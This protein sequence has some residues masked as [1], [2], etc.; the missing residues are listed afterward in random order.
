[1]KKCYYIYK[2]TNLLNGKSYIG[3]RKARSSCPEH[4][5]SYWGGGRQLKESILENGIG[6]FTKEVVWEVKD[7]SL[8]DHYEK[9]GILLYKTLH[10]R[11]YNLTT[12]SQRGWKASALTRSKLSA[13]RKGMKFS[14][15][16]KAAISKRQTGVKNGDNGFPLY[17]SRAKSP[18]ETYL[19]KA[20]GYNVGRFSTV[21]K[22][23]EARDCYLKDGTILKEDKV[24][25]ILT[26]RKATSFA[27]KKGDKT[28]AFFDTR[29]DAEKARTEFLSHE[30]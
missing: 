8:L 22:A 4:D 29:E 3:Q 17:I 5:T 26:R 14:D 23:V 15:E 24:Y 16:R 21:A 18:V 6:F 27:L 11:G 12:G 13:S 19:V 9:T 20:L 2:I 1:M 25:T 28:I 30:K 7:P 10:P